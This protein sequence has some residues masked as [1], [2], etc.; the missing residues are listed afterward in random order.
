MSTAEDI[1]KQALREGNL[2]PVGTSPTTAQ[3]TEGLQRFNVFV[4]ALFGNL[5]GE[6]LMEWPVLPPQQTAP[7]NARWPLFPG[8]PEQ[9]ARLADAWPYPPGNV[10]LMASNTTEQTVYLPYPPN[11]GARVEYV[12]VGATANLILS[13]NGRLIEGQPTQTLEYD[14]ASQSMFFYRSDLGRWTMIGT[15]ALSTASPLPDEFDDFLVCGLCI[16]LSSTYGNDPRQGTVLTYKDQLRWLQARYRQ[17]TPALGGSEATPP[18]WQAFPQGSN[19][20]LM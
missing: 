19:G 17:P 1:I 20:S 11:D 12:V 4:K 10:R 7:V 2:I 6:P 5:I 9:Q 16:R 18:S 13:G 3:L 14:A 8:V 15:Y